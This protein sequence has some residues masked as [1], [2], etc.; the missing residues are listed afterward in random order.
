MPGLLTTCVGGNVITAGR[1]IL[2]NVYERT[3][4]VSETAKERD[5]WQR[6]QT[7]Q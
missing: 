1:C 2:Y 3:F 6:D 5:A 4:I 7:L